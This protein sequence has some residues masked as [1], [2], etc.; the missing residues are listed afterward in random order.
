MTVEKPF[1]PEPEQILAFARWLMS[2]KIK[3]A[4]AIYM[5]KIGGPPAARENRV[6]D[7]A[8]A[9]QIH[10]S[11]EGDREWLGKAQRDI[12]RGKK[13][14][15]IEEALAIANKALDRINADL[16]D[17]LAILARQF[18]RARELISEIANLLSKPA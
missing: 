6:A 16:D 1:Q 18:L 13:V 3:Q 14:T 8:D 7:V 17:D 2:D 10:G 11:V 5:P 15:E 12:D 4:L 9:L